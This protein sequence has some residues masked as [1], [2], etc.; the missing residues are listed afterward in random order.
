MHAPDRLRGVFTTRRYTNPV[1]S[2]HSLIQF[3]D[4]AVFMGISAY[5]I[6]RS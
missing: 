1:L 6:A 3:P 2:L 4:A 5:V